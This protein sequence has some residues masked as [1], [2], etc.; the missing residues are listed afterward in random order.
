M[1][2]GTP[3]WFVIYRP[4]VL[5]FNCEADGNGGGTMLAIVILTTADTPILL[6]VSLATAV[7]VWLPLAICVVSGAI[8]YGGVVSSIPRLVPSNLNWT[9]ATP[10]LS[11]AT[12]ATD[13][14]P[15]TV[16][17]FIGTV[18]DITGSCVSI[19][20]G[21]GGTISALGIIPHIGVLSNPEFATVD[22]LVEL[23]KRLQALDAP[24]APSSTAYAM[25][26]RRLPLY[27]S[28]LELGAPPEL[29]SNVFP[30]EVFGDPMVF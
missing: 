23:V 28:L 17:L 20:G 29:P 25:A 3:D 30:Q 13:I 26:G 2:N 22:Q 27:P 9:P 4:S 11:E 18:N 19:G 1:K 21:G 6:D 15:L 10:T 8:E 5:I 12:A 16:V 7:R 14:M 24:G